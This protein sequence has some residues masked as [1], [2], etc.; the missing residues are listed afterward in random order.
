[1]LL[2]VVRGI[3]LTAAALAGG[4]CNAQT[5][6]GVV[7]YNNRGI[8]RDSVGQV[9]LMEGDRRYELSY[10]Q[11]L[12]AELSPPCAEVGAIWQVTLEAADPLWISAISCEGKEDERVHAIWA[13]IRTYLDRVTMDPF[14]V[15]TEMATKRLR[16]SRDFALF[17]R[18]ASMLLL[19]IYRLGGDGQC[20]EVL[21][22]RPTEGRVYA[23]PDCGL[24]IG[25]I[26]VNMSFKLALNSETR[27]WEID[28][29]EIEEIGPLPGPR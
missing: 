18:N 9:D 17:L 22:S 27:K 29:V 16:Q 3:L 1:M 26:I 28:G 25:N 14:G 15:S 5:I 2:T 8:T 4:F 6:T 12:R 7:Y 21:P 20:L 11:P 10:R 13:T 24:E 23:G 19:S